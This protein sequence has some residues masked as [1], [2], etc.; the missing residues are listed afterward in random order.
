MLVSNIL[1][2]PYL[3][4][5]ISKAFST[6]ASDIHLT[7][8]PYEEL[9]EKQ[10]EL[11]RSEVIIVCLNF[12]G[13]YPNALND[14]VSKKAST[15]IILFDSIER[16]KELCSSIKNCSTA[17]LIWFGFEDYYLNHDTIYGTVPVLDGVVDR[18]NQ[19]IS[20]ML[21]YDVYIDLKRLV[22]KVG[23]SNAST[24]ASAATAAAAATAEDASAPFDAPAEKIDFSNV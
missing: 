19:N 14:V 8:I 22:A 24:T 20:E 4:T 15:D 10:D 3:R 16:C 9:A 18:I 7:S 12:D 21:P 2:E 17:K 1:F 13:L 6:S 23:I 11:Q 5:Y